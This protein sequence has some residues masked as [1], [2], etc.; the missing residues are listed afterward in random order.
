MLLLLC[1]VQHRGRNT[2]GEIRPAAICCFRPPV[3]VGG[4]VGMLREHQHMNTIETMIETTKEKISACTPTY[5]ESLP[6][7][8][9]P[10][11]TGH[12]PP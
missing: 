12:Q 5:G 3:L 6:P 1:S 7:T 8:S 4:S 2:R 9:I 11:L 10:W